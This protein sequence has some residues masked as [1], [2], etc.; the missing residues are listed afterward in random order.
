VTWY[1]KAIKHNIKEI[2]SSVPLYVL[3]VIILGVWHFL[4]GG[5]FTWVWIEPIEAP[6]VFVRIFY[7]ALTFITLGAFLYKIRFYQFLWFVL[8]DWKTFKEAKALLWLL[9]MWSMYSWV[10]PKVINLLNDIASIGY[11]IFNFLLYAF[12]AFT[13]SALILTGLM[14]LHKKYPTHIPKI[15]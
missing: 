4:S 14:Y 15:Q 5:Q 6:S 11:N 10:V 3:T 8:G 2:F 1:K 13:L 12:P 9:L 7:S